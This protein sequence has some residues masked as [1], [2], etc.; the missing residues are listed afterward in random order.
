[1]AL[2]P[3][4]FSRAPIFRAKLFRYDDGAF[5]LAIVTHHLVFDDWSVGAFV[6]EFTALYPICAKGQEPPARDASFAYGDFVRW[7]RETLRAKTLAARMAFWKRQLAESNGFHHLATDYDRPK[8]RTTRGGWETLEIDPRL[9]T[10]LRAVGQ[11]EGVTLF[12][13]LVAG[14]TALLH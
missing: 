10:Q 14:F 11:R 3:F 12:M 5:V 9:T 1:E 4:D 6:R 2:I 7:Q 13:V 8:T